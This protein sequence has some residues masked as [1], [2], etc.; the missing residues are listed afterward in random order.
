M[1]GNIVRVSL[2]TLSEERR[3]ELVKIAKTLS[4]E[5]RIKV[6][7]TR[8]EANKKAEVA[9]KAKTISED[10]KF[11]LK[12]KIQEAVDKTNKEIESL[13]LMKIKEIE[14]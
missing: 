7:G 8:D 10:A 11:N 14:E 1:S 5:S 2:P 6:R 4:E 9:E 12:K 13:L 3:G